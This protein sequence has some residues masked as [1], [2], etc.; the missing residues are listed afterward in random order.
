MPPDAPRRGAKG[1]SSCCV[2]QKIFGSE[3]PGFG[4][5]QIGRSVM[6]MNHFTRYEQV[7]LTCD[8]SGRITVEKLFNELFRSLD[9][10]LS[11]IAIK[12]S[13]SKKREKVRSCIIIFFYFVTILHLIHFLKAKKNGSIKTNS[14]VKFKE[15]PKSKRK[16][17]ERRQLSLIRRGILSLK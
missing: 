13:F 7:F 4:F 6:T 14:T 15:I 11:Y 1:F 8:K 10:Q 17:V 5:N 12:Q 3:A 9:S 16:D 2:A